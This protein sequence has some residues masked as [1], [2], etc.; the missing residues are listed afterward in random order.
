M[1]CL[2]HSIRSLSVRSNRGKDKQNPD[3]QLLPA[4][5]FRVVADKNVRECKCISYSLLLKTGAQCTSKLNVIL[6]LSIGV[7]SPILNNQFY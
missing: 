7:Y 2:V 1:L 4:T 6:T 5:H 3:V